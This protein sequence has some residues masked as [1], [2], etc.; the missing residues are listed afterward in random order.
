MLRR[1]VALFWFSPSLLSCVQADMQVKEQMT[2][3]I[4]AKQIFYIQS[5]HSVTDQYF[6]QLVYNENGI[7]KFTI[8]SS[9]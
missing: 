6:M 4:K 5:S 9:I 8:H 2:L 3:P 7:Q 1:L